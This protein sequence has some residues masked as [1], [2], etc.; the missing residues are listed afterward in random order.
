[1]NITQSSLALLNAIMP[2]ETAYAHCDYPCG[3]YDPHNAIIG[4][5]TV[6]RMID[7]MDELSK[8]HQPG[9]LEYQN[10]MPR[11]VAIKEEHAERVKH[12]VRVIWGD[13][14]KAEHI[15]KYPELHL[16]VHGIMKGAG[17]S[18]QTAD[19]SAATQ[20]LSDV[21]RFAEIFWETKGIATKRAKAPYK[22]EEEIVHPTL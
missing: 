17:K 8:S 10:S 1:M 5:L 3:I 6:I 22:P 14:F 19:R 11:A 2:I 20:L 15:E 9:D 7:L 16:L 4:A 12:E 13:Y 21:N 18:K